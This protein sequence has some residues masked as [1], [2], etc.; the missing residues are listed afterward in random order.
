MIQVREILIAVDLS[1]FSQWLNSQGVQHR[2]VEEQGRQVLYLQNEVLKEQVLLALDRYIDEPVI[3]EKLDEWVNVNS[4]RFK[5]HESGSPMRSLYLRASPYQAPI[6]FLLMAISIVVAFVS[7]FGHGGPFIRYFLILD[8]LTLNA[9]LSST[10]D[11]W[12]G[13]METL[14][15]GEVWRVI[16]PDFIHFSMM[17]ITFNLL[18]L[19]VLGGQLEIQK[20]S[21][22]FLA[23]VIFVSIVS[24]IAQ[25]LE[26]SYLFGGMSGVVYGLVGYCWL[27]RYFQPGIF[28]PAVLLKF[29]LVWLILGYTPITEWLGLG[30]MANAAHLYGLI[31]GLLWGAITLLVNEKLG[32]KI[33]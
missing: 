19:W 5:E 11:R 30:K 22:S 28:F 33:K 23:L 12:N 1:R 16:S 7:D 8:P 18:M 25:L 32:K 13:L 20:G 2:I 10:T 31:A 4:S 17:H 15:A 26:T 29:S 14:V 27:W 9:D 24:N 6:I 3:H 21:L